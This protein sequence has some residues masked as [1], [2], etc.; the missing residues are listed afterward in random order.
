VSVISYRG[1]REL[2]RVKVG[3]GPKY[4]VGAR[5]PAEALR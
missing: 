1:R 2:A 3:R 5:V 4:I